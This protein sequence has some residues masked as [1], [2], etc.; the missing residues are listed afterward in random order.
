M[1]VLVCTGRRS[2]HQVDPTFF[3]KTAKTGKILL[4]RKYANG[5]KSVAGL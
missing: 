1:P 3:E 5:C 2:P 4:L